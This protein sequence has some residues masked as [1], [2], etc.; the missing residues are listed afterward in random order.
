MAKRRRF[1]RARTV[2]RRASRSRA[3]RGAGGI[4]TKV[5]NFGTGLA[6]GVV[7]T[8]T[9]KALPVQVP[10]IQ[11][12]APIVGAVAAYGAAGKGT[13]GLIAAGTVFYTTGGM[14]AISGLVG[15][16]TGQTAAPVASTGS[17]W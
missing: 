5:G 10:F 11:Q 16:L 7:T 15:G 13:I 4:V 14:Q 2:Y 3:G 12:A 8:N 1:A 9:L 17:N 6:A